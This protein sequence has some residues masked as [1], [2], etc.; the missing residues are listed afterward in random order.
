V[1]AVALVFLIGCSGAPDPSEESVPPPTGARLVV[2]SSLNQWNLLFVP[3]GG[4][5]ASLRDLSNPGLVLWESSVPLPA[6]EVAVT[7]ADGLTALQRDD[8]TVLRYEPRSDVL[9]R[10]GSVTSGGRWTVSDGHLLYTSASDSTLLQMS[11]DGNWRYKIG[12]PIEWASVV[13]DGGVAVLVRSGEQR[14]LWLLRRG[15][16]EPAAKVE[17]ALSPPGVITAW[18][19]RVALMS[20]GES[21]SVLQFI[22]VPELTLA[23]S[24]ELDAPATTMVA[25]PSSHEVYVAAGNGKLLS[26]NRLTG[27]VRTLARFDA[28]ID[29]MRPSTLG[30]YL[31]VR[32]GGE[33]YRVTMDGEVRGIG[34]EWTTDLP[35]GL[36]DGRV[37]AGSAGD[38]VLVSADDDSRNAV[39]SV[40]GPAHWALVSW[41]PAPPVVAGRVEAVPLPGE[42]ET[43]DDPVEDPDPARRVSVAA[44][45]APPPES[46][47]IPSERLLGFYTIVA[48]AR[49]YPG[50][51]SLTQSLNAAG[52]P[53]AIQTHQ[54]DSGV[55]WYRGLVGPYANRQ[56]ADA[57][58]RQ[59]RRERGLQVWVTEIGT[60]FPAEE[61][62][63]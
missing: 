21:S 16:S 47:L 8:G 29:A 46:S 38:V 40:A 7:T 63:N 18:G 59:L 39:Q 53:T 25:S 3:T 11:R 55:V 54:D 28:P 4:G 36:P 5:T 2:G 61:A 56:G 37:L 58:A 15:E 50:V 41:N 51:L 1:G 14:E 17:L 24:E 31:L 35:L 13:E 27:S 6:V 32:S 34:T 22:A 43:E 44:G 48:S 23:G 52:Y 9:T 45:E 26:V 19:R 30:G 33:A 60:G 49:S 42:A 62:V 10:I 20:G 57:A 12:Q